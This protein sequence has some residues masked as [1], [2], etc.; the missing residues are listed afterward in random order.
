MSELDP[1]EIEI[2][3]KQNV[4]EE[5]SKASQS[6]TDM[7]KATQASID[8]MQKDIDSLNGTVSKMISIIEMQQ[9]QME[10][11]NETF[12]VH[13]RRLDEMHTM[14]IQSQSDLLAYKDTCVKVNEAVKEGADVMD[15]MRDSSKDLTETHSALSD[16]AEELVVNQKDIDQSMTSAENISK[17][18]ST[19]NKVLSASIREVCSQLGL[20]N[21]AIVNTVSNTSLLATVKN[22][23]TNAAKLMNAQFGISIGLSKALMYG[24]IGLLIAGVAAL[25]VGVKYLY[26]RYQEANKE[27]REQKA[28]NAEIRQAYGEQSAKIKVLVNDINNENIS[29]ANRKKS[30]EDL[31]KIIPDYHASLDREGQLINNNKQAIDAYLV[32]LKEEIRLKSQRERLEKLYAKQTEIDEELDDVNKS[33]K[34]A[35]GSKSQG[36][37]LQT[38]AGMMYQPSANDVVLADL[39]KSREKLAK[40]KKEYDDKID[41]LEK[42]YNKN[43]TKNLA[44]QDKTISDTLENRKKEIAALKE[45]LEHLEI[46]S[47]AYNLTDKTIKAKEKELAVITG[48]DKTSEKNAKVAKKREKQEDKASSDLAKKTI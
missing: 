13:L 31:K 41:K 7:S 6:V 15:V 16:I 33:I 3:L 47:D 32:S 36:I 28:L 27:M 30:L 39:V 37:M 24:G 11:N 38:S 23:V 4:S 20:E 5:S 43:L 26:D 35:S 48:K 1:V 44:D 12:G 21:A 14:L 46:G 9:K 22:S 8:A 29:L 25:A 17:A 2:N 10:A 18:S 19:T 40:E 42:R 34:D 45:Q